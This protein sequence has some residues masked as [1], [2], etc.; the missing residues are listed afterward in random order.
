MTMTPMNNATALLLRLSMERFRSS[1]ALPPLSS[2][3][4]FQ[5]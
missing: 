3:S 4:E 2:G 5:K 1:R